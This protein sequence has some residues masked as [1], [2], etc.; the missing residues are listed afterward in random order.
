M[1]YIGKNLL[2][3]LSAHTGKESY[4]QQI[5]WETQSTATVRRGDLE[6]PFLF[7]LGAAVQAGALAVHSGPDLSLPVI[8]KR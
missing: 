4:Q 1:L 3:P 7:H 6:K 8:Y 2:A 5:A